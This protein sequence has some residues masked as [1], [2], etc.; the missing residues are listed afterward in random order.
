VQVKAARVNVRYK[1]RVHILGTGRPLCLMGVTRTRG[2]PYPDPGGLPGPVLVPRCRP[3]SLRQA[4]WDEAME[5]IGW[6]A[7][8]QHG[9]K[10]SG[11][12]L[13]GGR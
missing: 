10:S 3:R 6:L 12:R 7:H 2:D 5:D 4:V 8:G 1:F 11:G 9:Y 13:W